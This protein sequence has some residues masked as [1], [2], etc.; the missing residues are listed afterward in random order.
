[1][2]ILETNRLI[3]REFENEDAEFLFQLNANS[4]VLKYTGDEPFASIN[5]AKIFIKNYDH[6]QKFGMGRWTVIEKDTNSPIG[7]CGLKNHNN[8]FIDL[9]FRFLEDYWNK[10][11]ATESAKACID[12][13]FNQL[14]LD[15]IVG[16][17]MPQNFGS[18]RVLE[19]IGMQFSHKENVDGLH[20]ALI[21]KISK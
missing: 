6:Y 19:K 13:G 8:E 9:G 1:M 18:K 7:W 20:E 12:F 15:E 5:E 2:K 3:L 11:F 21:Y 14:N 4:N 10:G 16:R 17:T